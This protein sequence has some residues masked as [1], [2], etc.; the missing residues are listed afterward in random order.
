MC[1]FSKS[2]SHNHN[3]NSTALYVDYKFLIDLC[4]DGILGGFGWWDPGLF[5]L[6]IPGQFHSNWLIRCDQCE[7]SESSRFFK[8]KTDLENLANL[9][10]SDGTHSTNVCMDSN[11]ELEMILDLFK[12]LIGQNLNLSNRKL[13]ETGKSIKMMKHILSTNMASSSTY[14]HPLVSKA[15]LSSSSSSSLSLTRTD[16]QIPISDHYSNPNHDDVTR[17]MTMVYEHCQKQLAE[18]VSVS[19]HRIAHG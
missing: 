3:S 5:L 8:P 16:Q 7:L 15:K 2:F 9:D 11:R 1:P 18:L 4:L 10:Q 12:Q 14:P 17:S 19:L 13:N 6:A